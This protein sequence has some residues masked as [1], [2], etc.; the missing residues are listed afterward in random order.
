M[1]AKFFLDTNILVYAHDASEPA[2]QA[3]CQELIFEAVRNGEGVISAQVLSEFFVTVTRKI[4]Q[5]VPEDVARREI[6]LLGPLCSVDLDATLV[7]RALDIRSRWGLSYWDAMI[8][9]AAERAECAL[10]Y[11]EDLSDGQSYGDV[12]VKNPFRG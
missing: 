9:A 1:S 8:V 2:K 5:P 4:L 11:T 6:V 7:I 10:L 12:R 3:K